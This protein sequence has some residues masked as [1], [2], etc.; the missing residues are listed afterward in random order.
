MSEF[1]KFLF[2]GLPVRGVVVRLTDSWQELQGRREQPL[3]AAVTALLGEMSACALLLQGNLKFQGALILQMAGDGPVKLAVAEARTDLSYRATANVTGAVPQLGAQGFNLADLLNVHGG[4]RCAIT[5]DPDD[6]PQGVQPYQGVVPLND[7]Q[8]GRFGRLAEAVEQ[9]MKLSEQLDTKI[10]LAADG[11]S[12]AGLLI[13]R[14][15]LAGEG[16]LEGGGLDAERA[17]E[18]A[19]AFPRLALKVGTLTR[20]EL[21]QLPMDDLLHR[22]FWEEPLRHF[23]P[24]APRFACTC[25]RERVGRML[26][27][28]GREEVESILTER[29]EVEIAC[30]FCGAP[31]RFDAVDCAQLFQAEGSVAASPG[32]VH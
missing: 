15:P 9:Y 32:G 25:S 31:Y 21:L 4:G 14:M 6:R 29:A 2:E 11:H 23:E 12:A 28:L 22:L 26:V 8:A 19:D 30:N 16:N 18:L 1:R 10:M 3:P 20:E 24:A 17:A 5:L 27:G 7:E 13:Q